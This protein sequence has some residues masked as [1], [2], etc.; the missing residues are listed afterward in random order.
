MKCLRI[1]LT[2]LLFVSHL[3][4]AIAADRPSRFEQPEEVVAW[5]Y[6]DFGWECFISDHFYR[7]ILIEQPKTVL[8]RYF[9]PS[10]SNMIAR[11][12]AFEH[13]TQELGHIDFV[14]LFGSQDPEGASNLRISRIP[15]TN[16]VMVVYD[17]N[18]Q[19]DI[20]EMQFDTI[21]TRKGWRI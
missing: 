5:L 9:I 10:L 14:P 7:D 17:Q 4:C 12:R 20:M 21:K 16:R 3:T 15:G 19:R 18:G 6:R 2:V 1:A 13:R 8:A 11:D